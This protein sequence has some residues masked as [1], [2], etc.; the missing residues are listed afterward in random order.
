MSLCLTGVEMVKRKLIKKRK[1]LVWRTRHRSLEKS[2]Y[3]TE[4]A[5]SM[6]V[7]PCSELG[8]FRG[9]NLVQIELN[10]KVGVWKIEVL[11]KDETEKREGK[12][13]CSLVSTSSDYHKI[14][15]ISI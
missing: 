10:E 12:K 4:V 3:S 7:L 15:R 6:E 2:M 9:K 13:K 8:K 11:K 5:L 14:T 1:L